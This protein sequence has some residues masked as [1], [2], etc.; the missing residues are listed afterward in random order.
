MTTGIPGGKYR[1]TQNE[2]GT[3]DVFDV[4]MFSVVPKGVK[5]APKDIEESDL[6]GAVQLHA[7]MHE[8]DQYLPRL[9]V[10]HN[11]GLHKA[12]GAGFFLPRRV[13]HFRMKGA[14]VPVV[15]S[16]LLAVK[17]EVFRSL[18][19][20]DLPYCSVEIRE[21][22]PLQFGALALL[23]TE[24]PF[25]E[26]PL[27]TI[28]NEEEAV[29]VSAEATRFAHSP[30]EP[31]VAA[32]VG[33]SGSRFLFRFGAQEMDDAKK[34]DD[35]EVKAEFEGEGGMS[36]ESIV[37]AIESGEIS[38]ADMESIVAAIG[39]RGEGAEEV[40]EDA[41]VEEPPVEFKEEPESKEPPAFNAKAEARLSVLED[42]RAN[43]LREKEVST[44]F[45]ASLKELTDSGHHLS[46]N[47]Q[48]RLRKAAEQGEET[49]ALF[50]SVYREE[51]PTDPP[52]NFGDFPM[53]GDPL[54]EE[55]AQFQNDPA[56]LAEAKRVYAEWREMK[57][58]FRGGPPISELGTYLARHVK[59][60]G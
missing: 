12:T 7:Q 26:F 34:K 57:A 51:V 60:G 40:V 44:L 1:A 4:P 54:P 6:R 52:Q 38:V 19:A 8:G 42:F 11:F 41:A 32:F 2:D 35:D 53:G 56:A 21:W 46:D 23:D 30:Q 58:A 55:L 24:P 20:N 29:T 16:D 28:G 39:A 36:V 50:M 14:S 45:D 18:A 47:S 27:I 43:T 22:E 10:L 5:G 9:N 3:W 59:V 25:F 37:K 15:F 31:A 49:L 48:T 13:Q 33:G 17:D